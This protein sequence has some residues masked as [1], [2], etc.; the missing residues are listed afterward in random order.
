MKAAETSS[1]CCSYGGVLLALV[2]HHEC[3][4]L[5]DQFWLVALQHQTGPRNRVRVGGNQVLQDFDS[6]SQQKY[7]PLHSTRSLSS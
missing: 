1:E 5:R 3:N 6:I 2:S 4:M 7:K